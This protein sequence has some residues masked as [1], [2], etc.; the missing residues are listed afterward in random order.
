MNQ[1][2]ASSMLDAA[3]RAG[4]VHLLGNEFRLLPE[5][6]MVARVLSEALIGEPRFVYPSQMFQYV[7][8]P[9]TDLPGMVVEKH[10]GGGWLQAPG[11]RMWWTGCAPG[12]ASLRP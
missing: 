9:E 10:A 1:A 8:H 7:V 11:V 6:A 5:R 12:W 4:I 3:K 2:E